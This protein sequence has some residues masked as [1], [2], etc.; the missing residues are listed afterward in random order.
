MFPI[1]TCFLIATENGLGGL[2]VCWRVIC[3]RPDLDTIGLLKSGLAALVTQM[4][5]RS[6]GIG[7]VM[8]QTG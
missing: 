4:H 1:N 8:D 2:F 7:H 5:I 3:G 6:S